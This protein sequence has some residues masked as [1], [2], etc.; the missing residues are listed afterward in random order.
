MSYSGHS[1]HC[2]PEPVLTVKQVTI[3]NVPAL[4]RADGCVGSVQTMKKLQGL[5]LICKLIDGGSGTHDGRPYFVMELL[6]MNLAQMQRITPENR[7]DLNSVCTIGTSLPICLHL[8]HLALT[9]SI[10]CHSYGACQTYT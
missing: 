10:Y 6:G 1:A 9:G 7:W 2:V 4:R 5:P 3:A 8:T